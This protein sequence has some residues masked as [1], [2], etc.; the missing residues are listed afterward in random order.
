[1]TSSLVDYLRPYSKEQLDSYIRGFL[2]R[3]L[4]SG[5]EALKPVRV[6]SGGEKVRLRLTRMMM[7]PS[8]FYLFDDPTNHLDLE[9]V[10]ALNQ[11]LI[12]FK[13]GLAFQSHDREFIQSIASRIIYLGRDGTF[14]DWKGDYPSFLPRYAE[15]LKSG[16]GK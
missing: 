13:G 10:Q 5:D 7:K 9:S 1:M 12:R 16:K 6:L 2:G 14:V 3:M 11:G 15:L 4:F 8:N